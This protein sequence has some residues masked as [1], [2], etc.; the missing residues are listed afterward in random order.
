MRFY[1]LPDKKLFTHLKLIPKYKKVI[2][3]NYLHYDNMLR[4]IFLILVI[5]LITL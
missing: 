1:E 3:V 2:Q 4:T 5:N